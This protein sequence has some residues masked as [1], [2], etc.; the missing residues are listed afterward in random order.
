MTTNIECKIISN[1]DGSATLFLDNGETIEF[2]E[3][4]AHR[5]A[6]K[7]LQKCVVQYRNAEIKIITN[8]PSLYCD[9]REIMKCTDA[10]AL[11]TMQM[12]AYKKLI[13]KHSKIAEVRLID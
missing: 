2:N 3:G 11:R 7:A 12:H 10:E 4:N 5:N 6:A 13:R 9:I 8:V 1:K